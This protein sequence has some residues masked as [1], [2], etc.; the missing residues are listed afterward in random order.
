[1]ATSSNKPAR[2]EPMSLNEAILFGFFVQQNLDAHSRKLIDEEGYFF[3]SRQQ[4]E[5]LPMEASERQ[6][7][8]VSLMVRGYLAV[9]KNVSRNL[10]SYKVYV[11]SLLNDIQPTWFD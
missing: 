1:M 7:A 2:T 3:I 4:L 8:M 5:K 6:V 11:D 10:K 9:K